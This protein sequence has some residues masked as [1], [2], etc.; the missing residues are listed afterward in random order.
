MQQ[1]APRVESTR[2]RPA[3]GA[4]HLDSA[5]RILISD[6]GGVL[7]RQAVVPRGLLPL[8]R[9]QHPALLPRRWHRGGLGR[10]AGHDGRRGRQ[11]PPADPAG[12]GGRRSRAGLRGRVRLGAA[13]RQRLGRG[14]HPHDHGD[15]GA[16]AHPLPVV[17]AWGAGGRRGPAGRGGGPPA[18]VRG[19]RGDGVRPGLPLPVVH[20]VL[21]LLLAARQPR[22]LVRPFPAPTPPRPTLPRP[23][24]HRESALGA[25][26]GCWRRGATSAAAASA[27]TTGRTTRSTTTSPPYHPASLSA[28]SS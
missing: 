10:G 22:P 2:A 9:G 18:G 24:I 17:R 13:H 14:Q 26:P 28:S 25:G 21:G 20:D 1:T 19:G 16:R 27:T 23:A 7:R 3:G 4:R 6:G 11:H 12:R 5:G 15:P 8:R